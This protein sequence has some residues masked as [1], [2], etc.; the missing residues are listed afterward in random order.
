MA[1]RPKPDPAGVSLPPAES[2]AAPD[3]PAAVVLADTS[4]PAEPAKPLSTEQRLAAV[5]RYLRAQGFNG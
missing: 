5:E 3:E 2:D 1:L 4:A